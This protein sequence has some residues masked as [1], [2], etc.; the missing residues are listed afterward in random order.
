MNYPYICTDKLPVIEV[1]Q[2]AIRVIM[3]GCFVAERE[4]G[5][6]HRL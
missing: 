4:T 6:F 3:V 1:L 2:E 5:F